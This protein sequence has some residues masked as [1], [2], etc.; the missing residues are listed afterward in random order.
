MNSKQPELTIFNGAP[1]IHI[2][3]NQLRIEEEEAIQDHKRRQIE[4]I[5]P[6]NK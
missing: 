2:D 6:I 1:S 4:V 3:N 5:K